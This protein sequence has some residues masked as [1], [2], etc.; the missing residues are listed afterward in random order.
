[1]G[2]ILPALGYGNEQIGE[3]TETLNKCKCDLV[4]VATPIDLGKLLKINTKSVRV[5][6]DLEEIGR[7]KLDD[8]ITPDFFKKKI[9]NG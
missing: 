7:P 5:T 3:L 2:P 1:M 8:L 4:I 6:Y 9:Y